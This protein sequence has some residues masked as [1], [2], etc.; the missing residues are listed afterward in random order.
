MVWGEGVA[1][2]LGCGSSSCRNNLFL[3]RKDGEAI[4]QGTL[5]LKVDQEITSIPHRIAHRPCIEER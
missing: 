4:D 2:G 5:S 3:S 1:I